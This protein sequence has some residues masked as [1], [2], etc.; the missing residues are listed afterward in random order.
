MMV[1]AALLCYGVQ[2]KVVPWH[3]GS[4]VGK[5]KNKD[6]HR[7]VGAMLLDVDYFAKDRT[8]TLK[9]FWRR[10]RVNKNL[11]MQIVSTREYDDY[12]MCTN[13]STGLWGF[14]SV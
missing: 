1:L 7:L 10:F 11:F 9:E 4:R 13:G 12:F 14:L 2:L 6:P 3:G 8:N 5:A